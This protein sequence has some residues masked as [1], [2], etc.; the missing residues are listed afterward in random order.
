MKFEKHTNFSYKTITGPI[1]N[2]DLSRSLFKGA[3]LSEVEIVATNCSDADFDGTQIANSKIKDTMISSADIRTI[4]C[5][6]TLFEN[7]DFRYATISNSSFVNCTFRNCNFGKSTLTDNVFESC[8]IDSLSLDNGVAI[9]NTF[10]A[11]TISNTLFEKVFYFSLFSNCS[12]VKCTMECYLL[13]YNYGFTSKN[14]DELSYLFMER[15]TDEPIDLLIEE[16]IRLYKERNML[17]N[18]GIINLTRGMKLY[19]QAMLLCFSYLLKCLEEN[20][21]VQTEQIDFLY[22]VFES[23]EEESK[24]VPFTTLQVYQLLAPALEKKHCNTAYLKASSSLQVIRND[25]F[26]KHESF[27]DKNIGS[28]KWLGR[29]DEIEIEVDYRNKPSGLLVDFLGQFPNAN[30]SLVSTRE[31]SFHE[32]IRSTA[33]LIPSLQFFL[34]LLGVGIQIAV[35]RNQ[36][37]VNEK[38]NAEITS[39]QDFSQTAISHTASTKIALADG[40]DVVDSAVTII[41]VNNIYQSSDF[42]GFNPENVEKVVVHLK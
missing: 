37:K 33:D 13:G 32:L 27:L 29:S 4:Y 36:A 8:E 14:Y 41:T 5:V 17:I 12:F 40:G 7:V 25:A 3:L 21:I 34:G 22:R 1:H 9:L 42:L 20:T 24:L 28:L 15:P 30:A 2:V 19:D 26:F 11:T 35:F 16:M 39:I 31:G 10:S 6:D 23:L 18:I 38:A